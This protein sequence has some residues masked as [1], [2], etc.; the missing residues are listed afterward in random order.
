MDQFQAIRP[1][2]DEELPIVLDRLANDNEF[3]QMIL[4][5]RYPKLSKYFGW[6]FKP[7]IRH[8]LKGY[9]SHIHTVHD[10][11]MGIAKYVEYAISKSIEKF[12]YSGIENIDKNKNY[13]FMANHRDIVMDPTLTNY[14]LYLM[15]VKPHRIAIGDNLLQKQYVA[16]LM[17]LNKSFVVQRSLTGR[18][19]K[20]EAYQMLSAYINHSILS[21]NENIWIAQAEGRAKDGDDKTDSA[22]LKMLH[23]SRKLES[24]NQVIACLNL[25]PVSISYEY[26]PCDLMKAKE[27]FIR[28]TTGTYEKAKG[29]DDRSIALGITGFKGKVHIH[30]CAPIQ[31][32]FEDA[33]QLAKLVDRQILGHYHLFPVHYLAYEM[34]DKAE[35]GLSVPNINDLFASSQIQA[36]KEQWQMR[37]NACPDE[38]KPYLIMQYAYPVY[39]QYRLKLTV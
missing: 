21:D 29:E 31:S 26:D 34:W 27:L 17:R 6:L 23:I 39:N 1:Y 35:E 12:T 2:N 25:L 7:C 28:E 16:D 33:K 24:F 20:L 30:F 11:Q 22:L 32:E 37:L 5:F 8:Q 38:H 3:I 4:T 19:E 10:F 36:A 9:L 18:R 15:G 13:L 14:A